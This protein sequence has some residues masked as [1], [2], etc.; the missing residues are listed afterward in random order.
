M[1]KLSKM[2]LINRS[3]NILSTLS[4]AFFVGCAP[5]SRSDFPV[6]AEDQVGSALE[7][8]II[9][10][11]SAQNIGSYRNA[12]QLAHQQSTLPPATDRWQYFVG[13]GDVLSIIVWDH[14]ELTLPAG[15]ERTQLESGITVDANGE[16]FYPYIDRIRAAGRTVGEIQA[17]LR[18]RLLEF[19]PDPQID[20]KVA[21]FNSQKVIVTGAVTNPGSITVSNVPLTLIEAINDSGGLGANANSNHV[22]VQRAGQTYYVHLTAFLNDGRADGNP[23]LRGGDIINV[24]VF[25]NNNAY[26]LGQ[27]ENPGSVDL[28][29][30]GVNLTEAIAL[31][32]GL[33]ENAADA[34][35]IFVFRRASGSSKINVFQLDATTPM[36]FVLA[37]QFTL[38]P[39]D[40][41][42]VVTDPAAQW[43]AVIATLLP[44]IS[45]IRAVQVID[46][47]L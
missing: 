1:E 21:A 14:P 8:V 29:F 15:P 4:L 2:T 10:R 31:R 23:A 3:M 24:P 37:T 41:V 36:A 18:E 9:T 45:A 12:Q 16:I 25:E 7:N 30:D 35:G 13:P 39:Q 38:Q 17:E 19:I 20:V 42:Y 47:D 40:V 26:V 32:G 33:V 46:G 11:L 6:R 5:I 28:G 22:T 27:I 34:R 43:N 44:S